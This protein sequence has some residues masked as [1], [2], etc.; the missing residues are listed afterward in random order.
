MA[1]GEMSMTCTLSTVPRFSPASATTASF[2]PLPH[3]SSTTAVGA[4]NRETIASA[5]RRR[6]VSSA[7]VIPYHGRRQIASNRHEPKSS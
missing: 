5:W 6:S 2:S 4:G 3:P 1:V 7:L